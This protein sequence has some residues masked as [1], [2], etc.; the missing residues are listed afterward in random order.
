MRNFIKNSLAKFTLYMVIRK[1]KKRL[2]KSGLKKHEVDSIA[3]NFK[4]TLKN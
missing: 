3:E 2:K 4:A 1:I